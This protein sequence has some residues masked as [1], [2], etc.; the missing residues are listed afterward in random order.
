MALSKC[1]VEAFARKSAVLVVRVLQRQD[2]GLGPELR[3]VR[4]LDR[5]ALEPTQGL[6]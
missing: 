3:E 5:I 4:E 2:V 6:E 1:N